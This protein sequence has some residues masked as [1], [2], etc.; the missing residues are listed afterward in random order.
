ME[1]WGWGLWV[2]S[3]YSS[4]NCFSEPFETLQAHFLVLLFEIIN[5]E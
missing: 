4:V 3:E 2:G 5:E 1:F